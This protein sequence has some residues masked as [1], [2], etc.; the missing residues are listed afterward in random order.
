MAPLLPPTAI[1]EPIQAPIV[2]LW[3]KV[4][5]SKYDLVL[6]SLF[7]QMLYGMSIITFDKGSYFFL[8]V[9]VYIVTKL[10]WFPVQSTSN[11]ANVLL[12]LNGMSQSRVQKILYITQ[13]FSTISRDTFVYIFTTICI[14]SLWITVRNVLAT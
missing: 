13:C 7:I 14:Q 3:E 4:T 5:S 2:P 11:I 1:L 12:L 10:V 9:I 8:P 6:L